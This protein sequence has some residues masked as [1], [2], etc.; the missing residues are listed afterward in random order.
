M[1]SERELRDKMVA[2]NNKSYGRLRAA[3]EAAPNRYFVNEIIDTIQGEGGMSGTPMRLIRFAFCNLDCHFCDTN[4]DEVYITY[5]EEQLLTIIKDSPYE[6][7]LLTGGEP[8]LQIDA[9]FIAS[10]HQLGKKVALETNGTCSPSDIMAHK[11]DYI[12]VSPKPGYVPHGGWRHVH[13]Q[14][15]RVIVTG[16]NVNI[17]S[18]M[19][20]TYETLYLSPCF[21]KVDQPD[22]ACLVN[23][24]EAVK[25]M[26]RHD[27]NVRLSLQIHKLVGIP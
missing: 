8:L 20:P 6:W 5:T 22:G 1:T 21:N 12:T 10:L 25:V 18:E 26:A 24:I 3:K 13:V 14:E 7:V 4:H 16:P 9:D 23:A 17:H 2:W 27:S 11:P 19:W 15:I